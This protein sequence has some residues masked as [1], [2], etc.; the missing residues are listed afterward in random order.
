MLTPG[1]ETR[2]RVRSDFLDYI[3]DIRAL[4]GQHA[5]RTK[6]PR[7][8]YMYMQTSAQQSVRSSHQ[9]GAPSPSSPPC[10]AR[11]CSATSGHNVSTALNP[12]LLL[13]PW[14]S[15]ITP[16]SRAQTHMS[17]ARKKNPKRPAYCGLF[18]ITL[19]CRGRTVWGVRMVRVFYRSPY[20]ADNVC[21]DRELLVVREV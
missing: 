7:Y 19:I 13:S 5:P 12:D 14:L 6:T 20:K 18:R 4:F 10:L 3:L 11:S 15:Q 21:F 16:G 2:T 17:R 9:D 1:T 8:V